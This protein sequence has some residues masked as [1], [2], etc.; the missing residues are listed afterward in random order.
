MHD[1]LEVIDMKNGR[2]KIEAINF[3]LGKEYIEIR[4]IYHRIYQSWGNS[5]LLQTKMVFNIQ[6]QMQ[7]AEKMQ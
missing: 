4:R 5:V 7:V 6:K 2:E 1:D 3:I